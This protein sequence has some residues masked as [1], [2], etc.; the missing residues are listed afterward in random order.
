MCI[1]VLSSADR[2]IQGF[3]EFTRE[4]LVNYALRY[5]FVVLTACADS[6][7]HRD[8]QRRGVKITEA[9]IR[10]CGPPALRTFCTPLWAAM[11]TSALVLLLERGYCSKHWIYPGHLFRV[12]RSRGD[13]SLLLIGWTALAKC[14]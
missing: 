5:V 6:R 11:S 7:R 14:G 3:Y 2:N 10:E 13:S 12:R 4:N 1:K 9:V 8:A